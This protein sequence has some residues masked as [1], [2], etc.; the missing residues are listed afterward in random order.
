MKILEKLNNSQL[1]AVRHNDG[2]CLVLAG[3]GSGKTRVLT[4]R[5]AHLVEQGVSPHEIMA[6]TF[7]NKAAQEMKERIKGLI[8]NFN[9]QWIRTF[10]S[11]S[12]QIL[13]MEIEKLGYR[14]GFTIMDEG[15]QRA[16]IKDCLKELQEYDAKP[17]LASFFIKQAKNSMSEP[18]DY[19]T[20][21]KMAPQQRD[22]YLQ[23][24][25]LYGSRLREL[26]VLDFEDL[27]GLTVRL[28]KEFPD[29]LHSYQTRFHY[30]M[31]DE[32]QDTNYAQFLWT[33]LLAGANGNLFVVGDPDQSIYSWR[34]AE[35]YNIE[36]F[37]EI[38]PKAKVIT[39][40]ENYRSTKYILEAANAIIVNN[41]GRLKKNL[42]TQNP[43]GEQLL[44]FGAANHQQEGEFLAQFIKD[45]VKRKQYRYMDCAIFYRTHA[46]SRIIEE[47]LNRQLIP[48][49]IVG[50]VKFYQRK[51]IKDIMAYLRLVINTSDAMS[52][53]RAV[54]TP[55]RGVGEVT[56]KKLEDLSNQT[57]MPIVEALRDIEN[58]KG[59][60]TKIR[61]SLQNF[62]GLISYLREIAP[63]VSLAELL[64]ETLKLSGYLEDIK[65]NHPLEA[66]E[67][68]ENLQELKSL[69]IEYEADGKRDL[70]DF[71]T[72]VALLQESDETDYSDAVLLMTFHGAKGLEFPVVF[73]T[74][75]EEG[76]FPSYRAETHEEMEEERRLCYVGITRAKEKLIM[77][78][79]VNRIM[80]G[81]DRSNM[82]SRFLREIPDELFVTISEND[83]KLNLNPPKVKGRVHNIH[84]GDHVQHQKFGRGM[85]QQVIAEDIAVVDF[86]DCGVKTLNTLMA[87][88]VKIAPEV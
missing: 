36:R 74:G 2:P 75:M 78:R 20:G 9:G 24:F 15:E 26:N 22:L 17:E 21:L 25:R 82:A 73:M 40:E 83:A 71:L 35:P 7:T 47:A 28:F 32:Y 57:R 8:P 56:I 58:E 63:Q 61:E 13:R 86:E 67:R 31:I 30:V 72:E 85:V 37:L 42:I 77:T 34:G 6:I 59:Y 76:I 27:I 44:R 1:E 48:Y 88:M 68:A 33:N 70:A 16:V 4:R 50:A 11:A 18:G 52:F 19:F 23:L 87:P 55:R 10:H 41:G 3:A 79:A 12:Y 43:N 29:V 46:Q 60:T 53:R 14:K 84:E 39:L 51:E 38:Y 45:I 64:E 69:M 66:E 81:N 65:V 54:N 62:Y 49:R 80:Y 5:V